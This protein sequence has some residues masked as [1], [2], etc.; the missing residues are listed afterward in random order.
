VN[1]TN[2]DI[3]LAPGE[4]KLLS[5]RE[6]QHPLF[7]TTGKEDLKN[8]SR[9]GLFPNPV[10]NQMT[11]KYKNIEKVEI[12]NLNGQKVREFSFNP[13]RVQ[14]TMDVGFLKSGMYF[15]KGFTSEN[16]VVTGEFIKN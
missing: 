6:F 16:E 10:E 15:L 13:E 9:I 14:Q 1:A 8:S 11:L 4:Y 5:T 7:K 3:T 2:M 12:Y